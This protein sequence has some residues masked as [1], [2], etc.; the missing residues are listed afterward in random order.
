MNRMQG[1]LLSGR[2]SLQIIHQEGLNIKNIC[3]ELIQLIIKK[4]KKSD[5]QMGRG[6]EGHFFPKKTEM[7]NRHMKIC[8]TPNHNGNA[9]Q[10][11]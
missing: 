6:F 1:N 10:N 5:L 9:S 4:K 3:K 2:I 7:A 8:S 11:H